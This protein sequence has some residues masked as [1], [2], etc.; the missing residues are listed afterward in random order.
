[1]DTEFR[2]QL[3]RALVRD[4]KFLKD[5]LGIDAEQVFPEPEEELI[6]AAA[7]DYWEKYQQPIGA[8]LRTPY[9]KKIGTC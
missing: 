1:V 2:T 8:M 5:A 3:L 4:R 7:L 9:G 6:A